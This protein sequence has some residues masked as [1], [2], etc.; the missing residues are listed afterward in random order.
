MKLSMLEMPLSVIQVAQLNL[1]D[2]TIEP[3]F[4]SVTDEEI[5]VVLPTKNVPTETVN[6]EDNWRGIKVEGPLDFSLV[7][8]LSKISSLLA[9]NN[10]SIFA[11]STFNTDYILVKEDDLNQTIDALEKHDYQFID[12]V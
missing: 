9:D 10:I 8:I 4:I 12:K 6:Q 5:S 11:I 1:I 3:L 2:L 7:G